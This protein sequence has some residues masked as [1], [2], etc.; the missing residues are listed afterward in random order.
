MYQ[1]L[2]TD[3]EGCAYNVFLVLLSAGTINLHYHFACDLSSSKVSQTIYV[4]WSNLASA[5]PGN[6]SVCV[7]L[8]VSEVYRLPLSV[9]QCLLIVT[10]ITR[11]HWSYYKNLCTHVSPLSNVFC[12]FALKIV[13]VLFK[14]DP[15]V[16]TS[17]HTQLLGLSHGQMSIWYLQVFT[18]A[19]IADITFFDWLYR[20]GRI[21][22]HTSL[23]KSCS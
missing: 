10:I 21:L 20:I 14:Q 1:Y 7:A 2:R 23:R 18:Q 5:A 19:P 8:H 22:N 17:S 11:I 6:S 12:F 16:G 3:E 15:I 4:A 13:A 9:T